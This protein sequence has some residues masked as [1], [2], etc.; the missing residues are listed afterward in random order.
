MYPA[1]AD[2]ATTAGLAEIALRLAR[3]HS[4]FEISIRG[5]NADFARLP[6][7]QSQVRYT[8]RIPAAEDWAPASR[9]TCQI[10]HFSASS[11]TERLAAAR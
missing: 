8:G 6:A 9:K 11:W 1:T 3:T 10:P 7:A 4:S 5:G 2:A